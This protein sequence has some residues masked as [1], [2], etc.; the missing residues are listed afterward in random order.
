MKEIKREELHSVLNSPDKVRGYKMS[1]H[2]RNFDDENSDQSTDD[3]DCQCDDPS[4]N[5]DSDAYD[6]FQ[7][8]VLEPIFCNLYVTREKI[9]ELLVKGQVDIDII[10]EDCKDC[11]SEMTI[12]PT[13]ILKEIK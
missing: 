1:E 6:D 3:Y 11:S 9:E 4:T 7:D 8:D 13:L 5:C 12:F 10:E 2:S